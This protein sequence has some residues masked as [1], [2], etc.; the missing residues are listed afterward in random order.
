VMYALNGLSPIA[1][2]TSPEILRTTCR[3][4]SPTVRTSTTSLA[5]S[6]TTLGFNP[7]SNIVTQAVDRPRSLLPAPNPFSSTESRPAAREAA[8][9]ALT[10]S[11]GVEACAG[12][13]ENSTATSTLPR[14]ATQTD[15]EVGSPTTTWSTLSRSLK[16]VRLP[17]PRP[18]HPLRRL[19]K[20]GPEASQP[21]PETPQRPAWLSD[22]PSRQRTHVQPDSLQQPRLRKGGTAISRRALQGLCLGVS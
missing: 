19:G 22:S 12:L 13:P 14:L 18:L 9:T 11:S 6:G 7:P 17:S 15:K 1:F 21:W 3:S 2:R 10:P 4:V 5:L 20:P 8:T 16:T